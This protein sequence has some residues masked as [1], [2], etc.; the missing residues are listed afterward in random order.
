MKEDSRS[1]MASPG[2]SGRLGSQ[3][4]SLQIEIPPHTVITQPWRAESGSQEDREFTRFEASLPPDIASTEFVVPAKFISESE[5]ALDELSRLDAEYGAHLAPLAAMMLTA[6]AIASSKIEN[7]YATAEEYLRAMLGNRSNRSALAMFHAAETIDHLLRNGISA[8]HVRDAHRILMAE[9]GLEAMYAGKY[10]TVQNWVGGSDHSPRGALHIP[11]PPHEVPRL[12][13][14]VLVFSRRRD[15]P[16]LSQAAIMH[17][18]FESIHPFTDG[19][20]RIGRAMISALL[21]Q[22]GHIHH[23]TVPLSAALFA[24]RDD[25]FTTLRAYREGNAAPIIHLV[26]ES[27]RV[28]AQES[29]LT[30]QRLMEMPE[31]WAF[32][33][34]LPRRNSAAARIMQTLADTPI[35]SRRDL[36]QTMGISASASHR[37]LGL[38]HESGVIHRLVGDRRNRIWIASDVVDE[39]EGLEQRIGERMSGFSI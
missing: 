21:R 22:R 15:I 5:A 10:R 20:G 14:D 29:L 33:A 2:V 23:I 19:N 34:G 30:A 12:M 37:A 6:E 25:Y 7:E 8:H 17:A 36:E 1:S 4:R 11:P 31:K 27:M 26:T 24:R 3:R 35:L 28:A 18:Q 13:Q 32:N 9:A 39:L 16:L 38:L